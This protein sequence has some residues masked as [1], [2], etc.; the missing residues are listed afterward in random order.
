[1]IL[2]TE[3]QNAESIGRAIDDQI[4]PK[5]KKIR[6]E[7]DP[8]KRLWLIEALK[9]EMRRAYEI[10]VKGSEAYRFHLSWINRIG[11]RKT[12]IG[13]RPTI[14]ELY[15]FK[16]DEIGKKIKKLMKDREK[17]R[18]EVIA[19][20]MSRPGMEESRFAFPEEYKGPWIREIGKILGYPTCCVEAFVKN[21]ENGI[22][23]ELRASQQIEGATKVGTVNPLTYFVGYFFPCSPC[24]DEA[25]A[26][27]SR[28]RERLSELH[29]RLGEIYLKSVAE[30]MERVRHQPKITEKYKARAGGLLYQ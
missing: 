26:R 18:A 1:M 21:R 25:L 24:C 3:L 4:F 7:P 29:P 8:G 27:G 12:V 6:S 2:P 10:N 23:V 11:L 5:F 15:I 14:E 28:C 20:A 13:V 30:N 16:N 22:N 17:Y 9:K 19:V